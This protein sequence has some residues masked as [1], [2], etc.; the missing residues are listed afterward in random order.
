M[1]MVTDQHNM[2]V[3]MT[4]LPQTAAAL[5]LMQAALFDRLTATLHT[6]NSLNMNASISASTNA[7]LEG[8][9]HQ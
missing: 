5:L 3:D 6:I 8:L 4:I 2:Q 7:R 9:L 1:L